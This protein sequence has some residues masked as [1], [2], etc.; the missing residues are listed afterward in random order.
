MDNELLAKAREFA[1]HKEKVERLKKETSEANDAWEKCESELIELMV[2]NQCPS[3]AIEGV[4]RFSLRKRAWLSVNAANKPKFF[5]YLQASGNG[6]LLKLDVHTKTLE[7]FLKKHAEELKQNFMQEGL[8]DAHVKLLRELPEF[9]TAGF[10]PGA[11]IADEIVA[12]NLA[13]SVLKA[14]GAAVFERKD[15]ALTKA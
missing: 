7:G 8:H 11:P 1:E 12:E 9:A 13:Y 6:D 4:G 5:E 15:V 3:I 14:T 2:E 10:A